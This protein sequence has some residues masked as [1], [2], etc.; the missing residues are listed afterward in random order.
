MADENAYLLKQLEGGNNESA[1]VGV[2]SMIASVRTHGRYA[3]AARLKTSMLFEVTNC[4]VDKRK[5]DA[6]VW[7]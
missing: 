7:L 5:S 4:D 2:A 3:A 1:E 6:E